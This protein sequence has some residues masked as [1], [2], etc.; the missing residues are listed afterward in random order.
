MATT[1]LNQATVTF[2][3]NGHS[4]EAASNVATAT[5][6]DVLTVDKKAIQTTYQRNQI[7]TY[8]ISIEN[9]STAAMTHV[10]AVD[11]LGTYTIPGPVSVTPLTYVGPAALYVNGVF[12]TYI[13]ATPGS[14]N[15][16][17]TVGTIAVGDTV[18]IE[19]TVR[20][21]EYA[22]LAHASTITNAATVDADDL[23]APITDSLTLPIAD[24]AEIVI[25]KDMSPDPVSDGEPLTYTF[26]IYNYGNMA[27]TDLVLTDTFDPAP[28]SPL[29]VRVDGVVVDAADYT[30]AA[31]TLTL[32]TGGV[33]SITVPGAS[34]A[35]NP[36]TGVVTIT[37]GL[38]TVTVVGTI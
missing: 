20:V 1:I 14:H 22:R 36:V 18:T 13:T 3:Y 34:Y 21:N 5:L 24:F 38:V 33:Y 17:F 37:P 15:V 4:G 23:V 6:L 12:S 35:Q 7:L 28:A 8:S 32:P 19:Y 31:G 16:T 2:D 29:V 26:L 27:A 25:T 10:V 9:T 11:N 30:Y